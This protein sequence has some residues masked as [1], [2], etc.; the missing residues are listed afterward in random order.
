MNLYIYAKVNFVPLTAHSDQ[1]NMTGN[2]SENK[3]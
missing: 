2:F 3:D 1:T